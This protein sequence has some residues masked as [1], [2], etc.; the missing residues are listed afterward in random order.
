MFILIYTLSVGIIIHKLARCTISSGF[1]P[2][3]LSNLG[4]VRGGGD[5]HPDVKRVMDCIGKPSLASE[6]TLPTNDGLLG[7]KFKAVHD[8][9]I[10]DLSLC[11]LQNL[12]Q[13][14]TPLA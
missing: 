13:N 12:P 14:P 2:Y 6:G 7:G 3:I 8:V 1:D 5:R 11:I 9:V 10:L 4:G